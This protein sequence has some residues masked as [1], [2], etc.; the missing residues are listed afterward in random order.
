[1]LALLEQFLKQE[2]TS[3]VLSVVLSCLGQIRDT[4]NREHL[5]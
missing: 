2:K 5:E 4:Y 1:M 3:L